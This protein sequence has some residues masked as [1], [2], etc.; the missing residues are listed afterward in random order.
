MN[1]MPQRVSDIARL[2]AIAE[3]GGIWADA[4]VLLTR[5]LDWVLELQV[6]QLVVGWSMVHLAGLQR[7]IMHLQE[8]DDLEFVGYYLRSDTTIPASPVIE[9]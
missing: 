4:S 7:R 5:S 1:K 8:K 6:K 2:Y 3:H 9:V